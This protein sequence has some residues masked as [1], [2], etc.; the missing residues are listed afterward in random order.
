M[1]S[2]P[3]V[4]KS[5]THLGRIS[6][7][8]ELFP[9]AR[10]I[11]IYRDPYRVYLS[12]RHMYNKLSP[13]QGLQ[14]LSDEEMHLYILYFYSEMM[15]AFFRDKMMIP[16]HNLVEVQFET[17]E[18]D[19]MTELERIYQKLQ[20]PDFTE[21]KPVFATYLASQTEYQKN[22]FTI[23][24]EAIQTVNQHWQFAL[25]KLGYPTLET[26]IS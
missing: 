2:K 17:L 14:H 10:F 21:A 19:P 15:Q 9:Q 1:G 13:D 11:H 4:L 3:L 18:Q 22:Q 23:P 12:I 24:Q 16:P 6:T 7:L 20:L 26:N 8:L 5:P 25:D